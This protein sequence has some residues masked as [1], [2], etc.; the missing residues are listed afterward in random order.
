MTN[1][2]NK[3]I[4]VSAPSGA[5]K[6]TLVRHLLA[7]L[8]LLEFSISAASRPKREGETDGRD[9]YF[10]SSDEFRKRISLDEFVEWQEVYTGSFYGTL[11][12]ELER[13]WQK[14]CY[15]IFD[16]DVVGG[17]NLKSYFGESALAI[18]I[19]P[20]DVEILEKRLRHRGT[21]NE[22]SLK[23]RLDKAKFEME[24]ASRFDR[25]LVNDD[26]QAKCI[27]IVGIVKEF[28]QL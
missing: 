16:V 26:L 15:P 25:T 22:D 10:I 17:L 5:G 9:Y 4:V 2:S 23:I 19:S 1:S 24:F 6:T 3:A 13:I 8:P 20:P 12:S 14:G 27:E 28:L 18:F 21:E 11:K 7:E